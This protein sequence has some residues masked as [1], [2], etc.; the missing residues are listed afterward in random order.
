MS[1]AL[2]NSR[3]FGDG[4]ANPAVFHQQQGQK[5]WATDGNAEKGKEVR[6]EG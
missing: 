6:S 3:I 1:G 5:Q 2:E 4:H